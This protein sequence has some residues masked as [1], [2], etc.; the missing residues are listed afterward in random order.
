MELIQTRDEANLLMY[1]LARLITH[2]A[3]GSNPFSLAAARTNAIGNV[4]NSQFPAGA[5]VS[6]TFDGN[7]IPATS[8]SGGDCITV[9]AELNA[10]LDVPGTPLPEMSTVLVNAGD[11]EGSLGSKFFTLN[12]ANDATNYYVWMEHLPRTET[13]EIIATGDTDGDLP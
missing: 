4:K 1:A 10:F 2:T 9:A 8:A 12:S 5:N 6:I 3:G 11:A 13:T 7:T